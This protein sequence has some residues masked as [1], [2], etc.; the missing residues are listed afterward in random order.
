MKMRIHH[1]AAGA[2]LAIGL[3]AVMA[4]AQLAG[5]AGPS[6]S[7]GQRQLMIVANDEKQSW[8]EAG[9]PVLAPHGKDTLQLLDIGTDPLAPKAV[10]TLP[11][12][13]TIVGPPTNLAITSNETLALVANS[14]NVVEEGGA[15][16]TVPDTRLFVVDLTSSP[17]KVIDTL[18][19]GKQPSGLS[20]NKAGTLA[21]V[22]NRADNSVS[23]LRIAGM[24]VTLIDTVAIGESVAHV[25][26]TPDGKRALL[27]KFP[28][29]K[30]ALLDVDGEKVTYNKVDLAVGLWPYNVDVT[31]D[32]K[33]A[34]SADNGNSG[35]SDG[36]IDTV[37]VIDLEATPPRVIDK[38][39][40]GDGPEGLA[41]SPSGKHAVAVLL[42]GSNAPKN[43][44]FY[45]RNGSVV[46]MKIDGK[47]VTRGNEIEVRGL[48]EGAVW[49][50]DGR[51]LYVGNFIDQ[52]ISILRVDGDT[53]V[54]TG[55][56]F[57]LQ[58]HPASMRGRVTH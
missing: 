50:A 47:K 55:K 36:Q 44:Y 43:A 16:K 8:D 3:C 54:N 26:F 20:I 19:L 45:N 6:A 23:V 21:L 46:L 53:L 31:P 33:L 30:I 1:R 52:D 48:P 11:L 58:G 57:A 13:N 25:R 27:A 12:D 2:R 10:A 42:R 24:K 40:I 49:S 15:R 18:N 14:I 34:L 38:V 5:C 7:T 9:R 39:V 51:Y 29:H 32:G 22:A 41:V 17:P 28:N 35:A 4:L 37:S 56:S